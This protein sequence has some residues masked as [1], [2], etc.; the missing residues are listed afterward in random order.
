MDTKAQ[1]A[2]S[3]AAGMETRLRLAEFVGDDAQSAFSRWLLTRPR[4]IALDM[5]KETANNN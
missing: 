1:G 4:R 5:N 2:G 3:G